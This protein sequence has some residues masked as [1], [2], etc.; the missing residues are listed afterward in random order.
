MLSISHFKAASVLLFSVLFLSACSSK[1][2]D[3]KDKQASLYFGAGTQS[4]MDKQ[5]TEALKNLLEANKLDPDN[6]EIINN[7]AMAYYFKGEK[8][9]A[10]KSLNQALKLN[11]NNSD[12][13]TN[14]ASIFYKDGRVDEAEKIYKTVLKDLTYEKQAR[15]YFNLGVIEL[16]ARNNIVAAENYFKRSIKEDD[17]FCTAYH[18]LGLIQYNRRQFNTALRNFKEA[19]MGTCFEIPGP[20]Y[21]QALTYIELGRM[22]DARIKLDEIET[23]FKQTPYAVKAHAKIIELNE[24]DKNK[25]TESHASRKVYES[26]DF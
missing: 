21:Y 13:K 10:V 1:K 20:H 11:P 6:S 16:Q 4:L 17:N 23:R 5:Y 3:L 19:S 25:S 22:D 24:I 26:P 18:H 8:D 14:L 12:A 9:L 7:L 15:T 2:N